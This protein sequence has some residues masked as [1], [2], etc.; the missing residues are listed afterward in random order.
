MENEETR[1]RTRE[2]IGQIQ[3]KSVQLSDLEVIIED[4]QRERR[5]LLQEICRLKAAL[6]ELV[7]DGQ[8]KWPP[9]SKAA[10]A[11]EAKE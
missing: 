6:W 8:V 11:G 7:G 2:L 10:E 4:Y 1:R 9:E 3:D 5:E